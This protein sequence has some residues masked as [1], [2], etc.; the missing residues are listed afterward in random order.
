M[1]RRTSLELNQI[2][3]HHEIHFCDL[4]ERVVRETRGDCEGGTQEGREGGMKRHARCVV[5]VQGH[6]EIQQ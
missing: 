1:P 6:C 5:Q 3:E 2:G 4:V